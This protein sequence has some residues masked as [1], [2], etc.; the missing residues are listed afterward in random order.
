MVYTFSAD[1]EEPLGDNGVDTRV[2]CFFA[3]FSIFLPVECHGNFFDIN[4]DLLGRSGRWLT[5]NIA[6]PIVSRFVTSSLNKLFSF[7]KHLL[8]GAYAN[9]LIMLY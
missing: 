9:S 1:N 6:C 4:L 2:N 7:R 3:K 8:T 5:I